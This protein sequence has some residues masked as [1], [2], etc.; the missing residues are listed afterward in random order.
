MVLYKNR[1]KLSRHSAK[2]GKIFGGLGPSAN[3]WTALALV[4]T[5]ASAYFLLVQ[6]FIYAAVFFALSAFLDSVDGAVAR[7]RDEASRRGAYFDTISDRYMEGVVMVALIL[8]P[9]PAFYLPSYF[10]AALYLFGSMTTTYAKA[11]AKEKKL[12]EKEIRGGLLERPERM[13]LTFAG[14]LLAAVNTL[15]LT[16]MLALL[17]VLANITALQRISTA[18]KTPK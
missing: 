13:I 5:F 3:F 8:L 15:Y 12:T 6:S 2:I 9:L 10:W 7:F 16:Y 18:V 1:E 4:L 17:A 14:I 11:A